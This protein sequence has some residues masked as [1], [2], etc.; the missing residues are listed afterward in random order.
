MIDTNIKA[1][2]AA[3]A[4]KAAAEENAFNALQFAQAAQALANTATMLHYAEQ[5]AQEPVPAGGTD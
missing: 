1:N 5:H 4:A 3:L 2:I